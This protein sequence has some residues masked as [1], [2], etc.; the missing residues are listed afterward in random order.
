MIW[1]STKI[2]EITIDYTKCSEAPNDRP[3]E[4]PSGYV[5]TYFSTPLDSRSAPKWMYVE[6]P[7]NNTQDGDPVKTCTLHFTL[8]NEL[9]PPVFFYYRLTNFYQNH[10][11]Y[12][13][14]LDER[15]LK[16][17]VRSKAALLSCAPLDANSEG[18]P[19]YPCGLIAN[20][21]FND[22][23]QAPVLLNTQGGSGG[24]NETYHM[25]DKGIAWGSDKSRYGLSKYRHDEVVPPPYWVKKYGE[26]YTE[27]NFPN[28]HEMEGFQVWMRTAGFPMFNKLAMKNNSHP[29]KKGT[30][31]VEI[32]YNFPASGYAGTKS[33][34]LSTS[35]FMG[36]RNPWLGISFVFVSGLCVVLGGFFTISHLY[37]PRKLGD[38]TYLSFENEPATATT[39]ATASGRAI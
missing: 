33:I 1:G 12:V 5:H 3:R 28:L 2:Q 30:Y 32:A 8:P 18:R 29:M 31:A 37:K 13:K 16:G 10:R 15:Q 14:S 25:T 38:H 9:Q 35:S 27:A 20:S 22:T 23:F 36:G 19:Y 21:M 39:Q 4:I 7:S 11:R 34:V 24:D 17:D 26:N 6:T